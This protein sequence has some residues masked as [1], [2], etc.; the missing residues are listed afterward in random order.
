MN[1]LSNDASWGTNGGWPFGKEIFCNI[2]G[3][4]VSIVRDFNEDSATVLTNIAIC[5]F[6]VFADALFANLQQAPHTLESSY[7]VE[8]GDSIDLEISYVTTASLADLG[9]QLRLKEATV[10]FVTIENG[11]DSAR[12][13]L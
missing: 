12:I 10:D 4:Y 9:A 2:Y 11:K 5:D 3:Q 13:T 6:A 8:L 7:T 1:K